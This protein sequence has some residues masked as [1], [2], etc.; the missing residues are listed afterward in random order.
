M[1]RSGAMA[2]VPYAEQFQ[3]FTP[4]ICYTLPISDFELRKTEE[5]GEEAMARR[6][7]WIAPDVPLPPDSGR[8]EYH[9][10]KDLYRLGGFAPHVMSAR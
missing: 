5:T 1:R 8:P 6:S 3:R 10:D 2:E 7:H 4:W 9:F